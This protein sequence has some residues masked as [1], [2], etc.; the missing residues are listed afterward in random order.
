MVLY[1]ATL[2]RAD[3]LSWLA[4]SRGTDE[5]EAGKVTVAQPR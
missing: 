3:I 5:R 1:P 2:I 4:A